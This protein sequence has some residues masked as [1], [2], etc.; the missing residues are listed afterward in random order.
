LPEANGAPQLQALTL[1]NG[2]IAAPMR[3][4]AEQKRWLA[5]GLAQERRR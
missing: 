3:A 1:A 4:M 2:D 5:V